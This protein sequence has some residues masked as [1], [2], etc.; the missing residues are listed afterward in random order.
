[1]FS[2][3]DGTFVPWVTELRKAILRLWPLPDGLEPIPDSE[4]IE[5]KWRLEVFKSNLPDTP[6]ASHAP[7]SAQEDVPSASLIPG[8]GRIAATIVSNERVTASTHFQDT[9]HVVLSLPGHHDYPPGATLAIHPKNFPSDVSAF[10][11]LMSWTAH[12]DTPL[13]FVKADP[14]IPPS[15][16]PPPPISEPTVFTLRYLLENHLDIMSIP[17]RT[18]FAQL[19]RY[20]TDEFHLDRIREFANPE[21]IDELYDY[22]T[23]PRRSILEALSDFPSVKLPWQ[24]ICS[25][26]PLIRARLFSVA[27]GGLLKDARTFGQDGTRV[28]LL[29]AIV[30]YRT[31]IKRIRHGLCTRY[32]ST[33]E[34]GDKVNISLSRGALDKKLPKSDIPIVM[35]GPGTGVAPMR[36]LALERTAPPSQRDSARPIKDVLFFGCR[37]KGTDEYFA[38]EWNALGINVVTAFSRDAVRKPTNIPSQD[39]G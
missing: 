3:I 10:L 27:S 22:T 11:D 38:D 19:V 20:T 7:P 21:L 30:K 35:V 16:Y 36:A 23:R 4:P 12:A 28:D 34:A 8:P 6:P 26:L 39:Y 24:Q 25:I 1:M 2:S 33:L 9:R 31:I 14:S 32:V 37:K 29:I 5:P 15:D 18:F 17:R 13:H